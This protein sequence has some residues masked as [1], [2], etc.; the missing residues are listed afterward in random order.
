[1][2]DYNNKNLA[3]GTIVQLNNKLNGRWGGGPKSIGICY[4][5][6]TIGLTDK[7]Y[8]FIFENGD[9]SGFDLDEINNFLII[10]G[11][12]QLS[13]KFINVIILSHDFNKGLF[14]NIFKEV[15]IYK[16]KGLLNIGARLRQ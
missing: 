15:N 11:Y 9:N 13:Y 4:E 16:N 12:I 7:G 2:I 14:N 5:E 10:I 3:I 1:M 6:Y 8:S